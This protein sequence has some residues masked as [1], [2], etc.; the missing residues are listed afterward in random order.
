MDIIF[1]ILDFV[2]DG[3]LVILTFANNH[4]WL[5]TAIIIAPIVVLIVIGCLEDPKT[6]LAG[7]VFFVAVFL[8]VAASDNTGEVVLAAASNL[9]LSMSEETAGT[10]GRALVLLC[11]GFIVYAYKKL[12]K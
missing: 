3:A 9:G 8:L 2:M 1:G 7:A 11:I 4:P 6:A 5:A 12:K 10:I